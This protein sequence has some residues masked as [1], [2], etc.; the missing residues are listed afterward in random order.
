MSRRKCCC[1]PSYPC[2]YCYGTPGDKIITFGSVLNDDTGDPIA[3]C[4]AAQVAGNSYTLTKVLDDTTSQFCGW[5]YCEESTCC[6]DVYGSG[7]HLQIGFGYFF[8][9]GTITPTLAISCSIPEDDCTNAEYLWYLPSLIIDN[10]VIGGEWASITPPP[11]PNCSHE[12]GAVNL[13]AAYLPLPDVLELVSL[14]NA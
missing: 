8:S 6:S 2:S 4:L 11:Y 9:G 10:S 5:M 12:F 13:S 14:V 7:Y 3:D 1:D